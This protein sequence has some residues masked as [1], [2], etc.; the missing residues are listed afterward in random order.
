LVM[1]L[2]SP[3]SIIATAELVVPKSIPIILPIVSS[4]HLF[5]HNINQIKPFVNRL[6]IELL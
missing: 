5:K 3:F 6:I 4:L 2:I 1:I